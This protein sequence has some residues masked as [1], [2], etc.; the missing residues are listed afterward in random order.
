MSAYEE[1]APNFKRAILEKTK[2]KQPLW[3]LLGIELLDIKK[4]WAKMKLP[5][6]DK[7]VHAYGAVHGGA[8]FSLAD[9]AVAM[10]LLGLVDRG[11]R[12]T[13]VEMKINYIRPFDAGE[14][15]A[16]A[17]I[18]SKGKRIALGEVTIEKD[19]GELVAKCLA[20][21]MII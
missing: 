9:S 20:T 10:A 1:L 21:Y 12:F 19:G 5:F 13:T 3:G 6:S 14:I 8:I 15:T 16:E 18:F 4:G 2:N 7:L 11:E 17:I